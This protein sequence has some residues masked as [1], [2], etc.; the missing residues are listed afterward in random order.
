M[1]WNPLFCNWTTVLQP[2]QEQTFLYEKETLRRCWGFT[3]HYACPVLGLPA[4]TL[5]SVTWCEGTT[6]NWF[7]V[8]H[9]A[10]MRHYR[11]PIPICRQNLS[12]WPGGETRH[13]PLEPAGCLC[14]PCRAL[15]CVRK[16]INQWLRLILFVSEVNTIFRCRGTI[17]DD[18]SIL[19][20]KCQ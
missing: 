1:P 14:S 7:H 8:D 9:W 6:T 17:W 19:G 15:S 12:H 5:G 11:F 18:F 13:S 20:F 4:K 16:Q 3:A 10:T 2:A